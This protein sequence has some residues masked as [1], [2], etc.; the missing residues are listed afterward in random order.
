MKKFIKELQHRNVIKSALAYLVVAWLL[1][2]VMAIIIP[3]FELPVS[4]LKASIILLAACFPF[5]LIFSW[6]YEVTTDG[7]KKTINISPEQPEEEKSSNRL[8]YFI[9]AGLGTAIILL[10]FTATRKQTNSETQLSGEIAPTERD[11]KS[12]A[13]LAFADMSP[14]KD[15]EY[16]SDGIS[17]EILNLLTKVQDLKVI[18]RTS[19]F[20]YKG[21]DINI[22]K[23]G[24]E[25]HVSYVLEG[26]I[27]KSGNTFRITAQ[28]ID[29]KTGIHIWSETYDHDLEDIF[30]TQDEIATRVT[31][32]LEVSLLGPSMVST[33]VATDAYTLYLQA[34]Q[35]SS[36]YSSEST[37]NAMKLL[38]EVLAIDSTYA[39]AWSQLSDLY[40]Y[41]GFRFATM[42][43]GDALELGKA[44]AKKSIALDPRCIQG[45]S[46]LAKWE[47]MS[48]NFKAASK[49]LADASLL[50]PNNP[51]LL[52]TKADLALISGKPKLAIEIGLKMTELDPLRKNNYFNLGLY[53][54]MTEEYTKAEKSLNDY[55]LLLPN[56]GMANGLMGRIQLSLGRPETALN[57][58]EKHADPFWSLY[59]KSMAVYALGDKLQADEVLAQLIADWGNVAWPSIAHVYAFRGEKTE[60]FKWLDIALEHKDASLLEILSYPQM[61]NLW[62][63]PRWNK[64]IKKL[65]LP[66]DHGFHL[67]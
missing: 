57:Y 67:D 52:T 15:Q 8:S 38:K 11:D 17:E 54:W 22:K 5:W 2:Q 18:S 50:D 27:R 20:S 51:D 6:I 56:S 55:L 37:A 53:Y 3:A 36:Q 66:N 23:I 30:K 31:Q 49:L 29:A 39:Q 61:Q 10:I 28:L 42:P 7:I 45:Y 60:A 58:I 19:S 14:E 34:R 62:G 13:V 33:I 59:G 46:T 65:K 63:D 12:I 32:Q 4:L 35:L 25:L 26:S 21:K 16:F 64:F 40:Y 9:L 1:T 24:E 48:W 47:S 41:A 44:A 43:I